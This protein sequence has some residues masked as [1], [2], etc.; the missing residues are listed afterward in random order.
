MGDFPP[1]ASEKSQPLNRIAL[2]VGNEGRQKQ[3]SHQVV[4]CT[5]TASMRSC[6]YNIIYN[7]YITITI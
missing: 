6:V 7:I 1:T 5:Q 3:V 2:I 4:I